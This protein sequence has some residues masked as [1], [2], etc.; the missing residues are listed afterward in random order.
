MTGPLSLSLR[1]RYLS[2]VTDDKILIPRRLGRPGP[3]ESDFAAPKLASQ[4]YLD[5][6]FLYDMSNLNLSF[7]GGINNVTD[8][9]PPITGRSQ[10][11]ANTYP[12]TYDALGRE[13]FLAVTAAF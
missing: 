12:S 10:Q 13:Y 7:H 3:S 9:T 1:H 4:N 5:L 6:A 2:S 11:Q 8:Q